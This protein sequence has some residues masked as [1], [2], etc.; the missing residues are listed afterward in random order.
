MAARE[1]SGY[2]FLSLESYAAS[3][4]GS[5]DCNNALCAARV[6]REKRRHGERVHRKIAGC[7]PTCTCRAVGSFVPCHLLLHFPTS[8]IWIHFECPFETPLRFAIRYRYAARRRICFPSDL[9]LSM[10]S[11]VRTQATRLRKYANETKPPKSC[12]FF[13]DSLRPLNSYHSDDSMFECTSLI[14]LKRLE[15]N[16]IA[17]FISCWIH[18]VIT[19][20]HQVLLSC[21]SSSE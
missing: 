9:N 19:Y 20:Y 18:I 7:S 17:S 16:F 6:Q 8:T 2:F 14:K 15:W 21:E 5:A 3:R 13:R 10:L 1:N 12:N 11:A 4:S